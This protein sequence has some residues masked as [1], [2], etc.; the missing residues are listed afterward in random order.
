VSR[1]RAAVLGSPIAHSLSPLLHRTAYDVLGLDWEYDAVEC[2]ADE[3]P[4]T[5][6]RLADGYAGVSLTM[7]LKQAVLPHLD[8]W[9]RDVER[10]GAANTVLFGDDGR[11]FGA[12]TDV[13]GVAA[14]LAELDVPPDRSAA[15]I[16]GAGGA[17]RAVLAALADAGWRRVRV[18][19]RDPGRAVGLVPVGQRLGLDVDVAAWTAASAAL[20]AAPLVVSTTPPHAG[21]PLAARVAWGGSSALL[22]V[23]YAPWPSALAGAVAAAGGRVVG[24]LAML[25]AQAGEQFRLMTGRPPPL[26]AMRAAGEQALRSG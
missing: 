19:A 16:L 13:T 15:V 1:R 26:V 6:A 14:A 24:G 8:R 17:A 3:L 18:L 12:N 21:D 5:L 23:V 10:T 11:R 25:V 9:D 2:T 7:P 22:D 20:A 4:A